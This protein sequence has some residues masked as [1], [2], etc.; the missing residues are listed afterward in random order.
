MA[1]EEYGHA[2]RR[3]AR[4]YAEVLGYAMNNDASHMTTPLPTGECVS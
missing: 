2:V 4:I 1:G 3:G